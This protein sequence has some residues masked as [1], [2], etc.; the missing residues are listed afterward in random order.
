MSGD[1]FA[2]NPPPVFSHKGTQKD[3]KKKKVFKPSQ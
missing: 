1:L 2:P 3:T